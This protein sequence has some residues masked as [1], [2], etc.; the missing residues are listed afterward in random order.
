[1]IEEMFMK[2]IGKTGVNA[3]YMGLITSKNFLEVL[4]RLLIIFEDTKML[5][6][7]YPNPSI[8]DTMKRDTN[9]ATGM[10]R[11]K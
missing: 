5:Y 9:V 6:F 8:V 7:D 1:M 11:V 4:A 2:K 10:I 3:E